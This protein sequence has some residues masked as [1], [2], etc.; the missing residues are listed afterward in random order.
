MAKEIANMEA[1]GFSVTTM[2][3]PSGYTRVA[4]QFNTAIAPKNS[5]LQKIR[6]TV[7]A[8]AWMTGG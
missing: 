4:L 5:Q 2:P 6:A 3:G 1:K 7:N 8:D